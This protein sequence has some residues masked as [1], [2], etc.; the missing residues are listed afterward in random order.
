MKN[1]IITLLFL[2]IVG[3][4]IWDI[5]FRVRPV[6]PPVVEYRYVTDTIIDSV[7]Y[8]VPKPYPVPTPPKIVV[9]YDSLKLDSMQ[10]VLS[11]KNIIILG[12]KEQ[13]AIHQNFL[14]QFPNNPKLLSLDLNRDTIGISLLQ[15][16]GQI[17]E[18]RWPMD[19]NR[20]NYRWD[21]NSG[22]TRIVTKPPPIEKRLIPDYFV[23]GG[24]DLLWLSPYLSGRA[25]IS[26]NK[27]RLHGT[28]ELGFLRKEASSIKIGLEYKLNAQSRN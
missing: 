17:H 18:A 15:I 26:W 24:V 25:E 13:I 23:G 5:F 21:F 12:L 11:E 14:K 22:L 27:L 4:I 19:F 2:L 8:V 9:I 28:T 7:P 10:L 6:S 16:S 20:F 1:T 3:I